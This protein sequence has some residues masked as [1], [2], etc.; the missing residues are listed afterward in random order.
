MIG[1]EHMAARARNWIP[2]QVR[3]HFV[4]P[5]N[6][7]LSHSVGAMPRRTKFVLTEQFLDP[8]ANGQSWADWMPILN[9]YR[10]RLSTLFGVPE[11]SVCPQT[12]ISSGLTKILYCRPQSAGRN[13]IVLSAADFPTNGFVFRQAERAG[14]ELKFVDGDIC[15]PRNW[16]AAIDS[17]TAIVHITH[18]LSNSSHILPVG[19]IA[20]HARET[21]AISIADIAQSVG[22]VPVDLL[23]WGVDFALGSGVKFLCCGPGACFLYV[24]PEI[25]GDCRPIDVG[26]FSHEDP[27][28]MDIHDFRYADDAMRFFGGTPS[29]MPLAAANAALSLWQEIGLGPVYARIR[30]HIDWLR[31]SVPAQC[32]KSP[33]IRDVSGATLVVAPHDRTAFSA[34]LTAEN[35]SYDERAHGF[36]FSVHGYITDDEIS[37]LASLVARAAG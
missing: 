11:G 2:N 30:S 26:W 36:R 12:N 14:Y 8:W 23:G 25:I 6:Y 3:E 9:E 32:L 19:E 29:V 35:I 31:A 28:E 27:F 20:K 21:G 17:H 13:V 10:G 37:R 34:A 5:E 4:V 33:T 18:A 7:F 15:D 16:A 22:A 24:R 1:A